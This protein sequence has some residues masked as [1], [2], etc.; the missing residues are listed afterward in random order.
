MAS[1]F[2]CPYER[3]KRSY[4]SCDVFFKINDVKVISNKVN[5]KPGTAWGSILISHQMVEFQRQTRD[6]I[7]LI[8]CKQLN[9]P[10]MDKRN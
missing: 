5:L 4:M 2:Y 3:Y 9:G 7:E 8:V 10:K 1:I 6:S